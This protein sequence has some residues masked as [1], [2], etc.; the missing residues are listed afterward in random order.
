MLASGA[1]ATTNRLPNSDSAPACGMSIQTSD[2]SST[3]PLATSGAAMIAA[4]ITA[5]VPETRLARPRGDRA[6]H[7]SAG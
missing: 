7:L 3:A 4:M 5:V 6:A 1:G 2:G